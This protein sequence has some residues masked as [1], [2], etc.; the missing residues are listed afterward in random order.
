MPRV[1]DPLRASRPWALRGVPARA[2][3]RSSKTDR[4][5]ATP[6]ASRTLQ[7]SGLGFLPQH[8]QWYG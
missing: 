5:W 6:I 3:A 2:R 7:G 4:P 8:R 1:G